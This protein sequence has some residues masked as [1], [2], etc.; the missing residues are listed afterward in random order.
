[1]KPNKSP[2][3]DGIPPSFIMQNWDLMSGDIC[4]A[5]KSFFSNGFLL[6]EMNRTWD[7][8]IE[9]GQ[10][11]ILC[12]VDGAWKEDKSG[13]RCSAAIG[14]Q[15]SINNRVH[16]AGSSRILATSPCQ[17]EIRALIE[18]AR[19]AKEIS[20]K[21]VILTDSIKIINLMKNPDSADFD[22]K[23]DILIALNL[24]NTE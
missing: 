22:C 17:S 14:W 2:G 10:Q 3:P 18:G 23:N 1:M 5:V 13:S 9:G 6:A 24:C 19:K 15:I 4:A 8:G 16:S 20:N 11:G 21:V 12:V 7:R